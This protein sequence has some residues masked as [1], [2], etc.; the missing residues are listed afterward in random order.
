MEA[1]EF[2]SEMLLPMDQFKRIALANPDLNE[3]KAA[4][5]H[6][7]W[8]AIARKL[9]MISMSVVTIYD[10]L[11]LTR[12]WAPDGVVYPRTPTATEFNTMKTCFE[13]KNVTENS[14]DFI[15]VTAYYIDENPDFIRIILLTS[16]KIFE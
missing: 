2:A 10:N 14:D 15:K 1:D 11:N 9:A 5:E 7:S 8:E 4:F 16:V 12:R 6:A 3:L 13:L